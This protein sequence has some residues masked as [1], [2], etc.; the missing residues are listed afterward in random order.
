MKVLMNRQERAF[1]HKKSLNFSMEQM[2]VCGHYQL[3]KKKAKN[4]LPHF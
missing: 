1:S 2:L 4:L 3:R